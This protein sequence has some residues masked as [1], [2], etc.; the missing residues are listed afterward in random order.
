LGGAERDECCELR[1]LDGVFEDELGSERRSV[2]IIGGFGERDGLECLDIV[3]GLR[4]DGKEDKEAL[5][6][7]AAAAVPLELDVAVV[8]VVAMA[9]LA[10]GRCCIA[11]LVALIFLYIGGGG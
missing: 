4:E 1:P 9:P 5:R 11:A 7:A 10:V 6:L 2:S 3:E 8:S